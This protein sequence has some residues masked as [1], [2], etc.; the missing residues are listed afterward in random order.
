MLRTYFKELI[1][2]SLNHREMLSCI[3][4]PEEWEG[5]YKMAREQTLVGALFEGIKRLPDAQKPP[6]KVLFKWYKRVGEIAAE[7]RRMNGEA[8]KVCAFF[9]EQGFD[10]AV[11]KGQ[12]VAMY[13]PDPYARISGD[14]DLW[15][16]PKNLCKER[17][18]WL[19]ENRLR[20]YE[21]MRS[22][23]EL[24]GMNYQHVHCHFFKGTSVEVHITPSY[25]YNFWHNRRLQRFFEGTA[26]EQFSNIRNLPDEIG[27]ISAPTL[28]FDRFYILH[29][30]Y[31]HLLGE[32]VGFR[33]LMDYYY[34]L[35]QGGSEESR[36]RTMQLFRQ[37]GMEKFVAA[38]MWVMQ[39]VFGLGTQY[40][41]C[42]PDAKE[43]AFLLEEVWQ[44]GN[45]GHHDERF[46]RTHY[47]RL[48]SRLWESMKRKARYLTH[49]PQ[50]ILF[51]LPFRVWLYLWRLGVERK[52]N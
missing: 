2:I 21:F 41:L 38:T 32:G 46:D 35:K 39:E 20:I 15:I 52:G 5:L 3:P 51:D 34:V 27:E 6:K 24:E 26:A 31:G 22:H 45:F 40:I 42:A 4:T 44:A 18:G 13:Y 37:L 49:Y 17:K 33:Q 12:A 16:A 1:S 29:H 50:E 7:N 47:N 11:M 30:I 23:G 19:N 14:I 9:R 25:F 43:G 48:S 36:A 8:V 10:C 28:E